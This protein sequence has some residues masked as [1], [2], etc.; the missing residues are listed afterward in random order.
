M[1][2]LVRHIGTQISTINRRIS[3]H[4][5]VVPLNEIDGES[6]IVRAR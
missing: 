1:E 3:A 2:D 4:S 6:A 5:T